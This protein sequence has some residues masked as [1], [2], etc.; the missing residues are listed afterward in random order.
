MGPLL[1]PTSPSATL[2]PA[3]RIIGVVFV[4]GVGEQKQ[5][6]TIREQGGPILEWI[7][8]WYNA[9]GLAAD[10]V[11]QPQ[12]A[13]L[14]YGAPLTGPA[15]FSVHL[16]A[17]D[18]DA[19]PGE[20]PG[21]KHWDAATWVMAEGWW[22][23]RLEAPSMV[24]MLKWSLRILSR[25]WFGLYHE[26][27]HRTRERTLYDS[28]GGA[29]LGRLWERIGNL[30]LVGVEIPLALLSYPFV[31]LLLIVAQIPIDQVQ[32]FV[33]LTLLRPLLIDRVGDFWI[34]LHDYPGAM[35]IRRAVEESIDDLVQYDKC[36][37]IVVVAH[38]QGAVVAFDALSS[39]GITNIALVHRFITIGAALNKA[40]NLEEGVKALNG[41]LPPTV[42]RWIDLWANYDPVPGGPLSRPG[43]PLPRILGGVRLTNG[44][45]VVTD[46]DSYWRNPE[47]FL[48]RIA[49]EID[50]PIE[51]SPEEDAVSSRFWPG[52]TRQ[53]QLVTRRAD[54]VHALVFWRCVAFFVGVLALLARSAVPG[55]FSAMR[56]VQDGRAWWV[57]IRA[58]PGVD[59]LVKPLEA[60]GTW[61]DR[62]LA[63]VGW[64]LEPVSMAILAV[65]GFAAIIEG[66]YLLT[67]VFP[68]GR[69]DRLQSDDVARPPEH[70]SRQSTGA[71]WRVPLGAALVA[72]PGL[73]ISMWP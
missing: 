22:A 43:A 11:L 33:I 63:N 31:V 37:E 29:R 50:A 23:A 14:S 47:E 28:A 16:P 30:L 55:G 40:W 19:E 38:S 71:W 3:P 65:V 39:G 45:N 34:Y 64:S 48:A 58:V 51:H 52:G 68:Y 18:R 36:T 24:T 21:P 5:S 59:L 54:R 46:H 67:L 10:R 17:Y 53:I 61:I 6:S 72:L 8:G 62:T 32:K 41:Q 13:K 26:A 7:W 69:W 4:H 42:K 20:E 49:R 1:V 9:R 35:H 70:W 2:P 57:A 15:R 60:I 73:A 66:A 12:W 44:I 27:I 25:F 56:L